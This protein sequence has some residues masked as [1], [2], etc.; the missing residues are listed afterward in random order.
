MLSSR[1]SSTAELW[2]PPTK[3]FLDTAPDPNPPV[4]P[5]QVATLLD[6]RSLVLDELGG[7]RVGPDDDDLQRDWLAAPFT[8]VAYALT[9]TQLLRR[10]R[11][12]RWWSHASNRQARASGSRADPAPPV[13]EIWDP[14]T[15]RFHLTGSTIWP[16]RQHS[17]VRLADGRVLI[18]G[19]S[20]TSG[21]TSMT[22]AEIFDPG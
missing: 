15:G 1:P 10:S 6:G 8:D 12:P 2:D 18:L 19:N 5:S 21:P 11:P 20:F 13:A 14:A 3:T 17:A 9:V 16:R 22:S 7:A 4:A